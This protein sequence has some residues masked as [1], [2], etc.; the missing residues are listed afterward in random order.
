MKNL[1]LIGILVFSLANCEKSDDEPMDLNG[2]WL[3]NSHMTDT[4]VFDTRN[5]MFILYRGYELRNGFWLPKYLSGP[6]LFE[7]NGDSINLAGV[8][9]GPFYQNYYFNLDSKKRQ[10]NVGN[11][12]VDSLSENHILTFSKML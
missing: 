8:L 4:L 6:Y 5:S 10:I 1:L 12:F 9:S 3:E 11:F 2:A 7:I